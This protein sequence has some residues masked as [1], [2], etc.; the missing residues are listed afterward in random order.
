MFAGI[1]G[2]GASDATWQE[3]LEI[4][5]ATVENRRYGGAGVDLYKAFDMTDRHLIYYIMRVGGL[6]ERIVGT[7]KRLFEKLQCRNK[8]GLGVGAPYAKYCALAQGCA[9]SMPIFAL[10]LRPWILRMRTHGVLPRTLADDVRIFARQS[11]LQSEGIP[12]TMWE[13][14]REA[15]EGTFVFMDCMGA[16]ISISKSS[17]YGSDRETRRTLAET[18]WGT[19]L[20][21]ER[22][23]R[24]VH[25]C[26]ANR[27]DPNEIATLLQK[28]VG[29]TIEVVTTK[30]KGNTVEVTQSG[31]D[32]D[33][34]QTCYLK[35]PANYLP[36]MIAH[37]LA[38]NLRAQDVEG[39]T[40]TVGDTPKQEYGT[41][42]QGDTVHYCIRATQRIPI[43]YDGRS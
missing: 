9:I 6:P 16:A 13:R 15:I 41:P 8:M 24:L 42:N 30:P 1:G 19:T 34:Q 14:V 33:S 2:V 21:P 20:A 35:V 3:A 18:Q 26:H 27:R 36:G 7:Y 31:R 29:Q 37:I 28:A 10:L 43:E 39:G 4:E 25:E 32:V 12:C 23:G 38:K 5:M 22:G 17:L 11:G 40:E